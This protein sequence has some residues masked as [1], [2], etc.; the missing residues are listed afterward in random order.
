MKRQ[1]CILAALIALI[2][3]QSQSARAQSDTN[4]NWI[5]TQK[6]IRLTI[7]STAVGLGAT[8]AYLGLRHE[9]N[10]VR[11]PPGAAY[12]L[13]TVWCASAFPIVGTLW[14]QRPLT[15]REVYIGIANCAVPVV[16]GW[17][18][19]AAFRGQPWYEGVAAHR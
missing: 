1:F 18:V 15:T 5:F 14:V 2:G 12:A 4:W 10:A 7:T 3:L 17:I 6:D 19:D 13:T 11:P 16:G 9:P 8:A